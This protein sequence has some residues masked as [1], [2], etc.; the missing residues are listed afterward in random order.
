MTTLLVVL[1]LLVIV[2]C[3]AFAEDAHTHTAYT[4]TVPA[5]AST[6]VPR[7]NRRLLD[8]HADAG[9]RQV[10]RAHREASRSSTHR[11]RPKNA[12]HKP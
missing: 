11:T 7:I 2:W 10:G 3:F 12:C 8:G 9:P 4:P 1:S 6:G 5:P